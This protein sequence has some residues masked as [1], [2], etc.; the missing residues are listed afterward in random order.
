M[1]RL[2]GSNEKIQLMT[3]W[4]QKYLIKD[5]LKETIEWFMKKSNLDKYKF[6]NYNI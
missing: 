1:Y 6:D 3:N 2:F 5:G 4:K